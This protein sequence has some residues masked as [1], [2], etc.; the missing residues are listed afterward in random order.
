MR[1][2]VVFLIVEPAK[3]S[4]AFLPVFNFP[5][6]EPLIERDPLHGVAMQRPRPHLETP[7]HD[8]PP[9]E[10]IVNLSHAAFRFLA[11]FGF[12]W[13]IGFAAFFRNSFSIS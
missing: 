1:R 8:E 9:K 4:S 10:L 7:R 5:P 11:F 12:G 13:G 6:S 3:A 2:L